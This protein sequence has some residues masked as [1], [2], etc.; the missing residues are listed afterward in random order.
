M[1]SKSFKAGENF[2]KIMSNFVVPTDG[3]VLL[4]AFVLG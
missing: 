4:D 1:H 3:L 2:E